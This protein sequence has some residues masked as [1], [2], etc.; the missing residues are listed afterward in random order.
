MSPS[1]NRIARVETAVVQR[2]MRDEFVVKGGR[3]LH[4]ASEF[5]LV[6]VVAEDGTCGYGEVSA[7]PAW[8]GEDAHTAEHVLRNHL[9][10]LV[11]GVPLLEAATLSERFDRVIAGNWFT[12]AGLQSALLDAEARHL[13]VPMVAL[14]GGARREKVPLKVSVS[15]D[16]DEVAHAIAVATGLGF[17]SFKVKVGLGVA[18]DVARVRAARQALGPSGLLGVDA[19]GGWSIAE[20]RRAIRLM[21]V[22]DLAFVEQPVAEDDLEGLA[23]V[24]ADGVVVVADESVYSAADVLRVARLEAADVV[25]IYV[26][27]SGGPRAA[28][29]LAWLA[30]RCGL[31]VVIGS[32]GEMGIGA[33]VQTH[34]ACAL[35]NLGVIPHDIHGDLLYTEPTVERGV[36][37][38]SGQAVL[39]RGAGLGVEPMADLIADLR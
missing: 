5:V 36:E 38:S 12:K 10:P 1:A 33:A 27:K 26:G 20:A 19:N 30:R 35:A 8:S 3:G 28:V 32:N 21:G 7:T 2:T 4:A 14:L 34:V 17:S 23:R 31:G 22:D 37:I 9:I 11:V 16:P 18:E 25:S 13:G 15:G 24:R 6:R 29:Q 39:P